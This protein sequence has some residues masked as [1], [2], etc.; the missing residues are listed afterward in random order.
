MPHSSSIFR[1]TTSLFHISITR[2]R[3]RWKLMTCGQNFRLSNLNISTN[4][5]TFLSIHVFFDLLFK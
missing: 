5:Q 2:N 3:T 1:Q 4:L